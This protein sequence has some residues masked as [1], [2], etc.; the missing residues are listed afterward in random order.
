MIGNLKF[1]LLLLVL[2]IIIDLVNSI[3]KKQF[4]Y[5]LKKNPNSLNKITQN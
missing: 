3:R 2:V 5:S 1:I 4:K